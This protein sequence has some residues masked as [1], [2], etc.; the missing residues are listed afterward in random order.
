[1]NQYQV[2]SRC[3]IGAWQGRPNHRH[4]GRKDK[5]KVMARA[6]SSDVSAGVTAKLY[7]LQAVWGNRH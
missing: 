2:A 3:G 5:K 6:V 7:P 4:N 1:M